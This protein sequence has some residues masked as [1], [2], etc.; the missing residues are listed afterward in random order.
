MSQCP[1]CLTYNMKW[2]NMWYNM[3]CIVNIWWIL[4]D[5][6]IIIKLICNKYKIKSGSHNLIRL[7][8]QEK[9]LSLSSFRAK[10]M[11]GHVY[12]CM[13][14]WGVCV[15]VV[16]VW[17]SNRWEFIIFRVIHIRVKLNSVY[18]NVETFS[19]FLQCEPYNSR[20]PDSLG[21][22]TAQ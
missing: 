20:K 14:R 5:N 9:P 4:I 2:Y 16:P 19:L 8:D 6:K 12:M 13:R 11:G 7:Y 10:F 18:R 1:W 22:R 17:R 21:A 15:V 3:N